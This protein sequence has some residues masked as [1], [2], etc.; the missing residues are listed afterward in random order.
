MN[1]LWHSKSA[2]TMPRRNFRQTRKRFNSPRGCDFLAGSVATPFPNELEIILQEYKGST[3]CEPAYGV[4][5]GVG[6]IR[7]HYYCLFSGSMCCLAVDTHP[8]CSGR[9]EKMWWHCQ[10]LFPLS[11]RWVIVI[12]PVLSN[13]KTKR[14]GVTWAHVNAPESRIK[15]AEG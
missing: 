6:H 5:S 4:M 7:A 10:L 15:R 3:S 9:G 2:Q 13:R 8:G 14:R 12:P 1:S 11:Q